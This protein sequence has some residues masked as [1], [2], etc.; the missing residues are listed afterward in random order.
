M[1]SSLR[2]SEQ[3]QRDWM[4][5]IGSTLE[6][7]C[8]MY[9]AVLFSISVLRDHYEL[10]FGSLNSN[11]SHLGLSIGIDYV[12]KVPMILIWYR[13]SVGC[14]VHTSS[15]DDARLDELSF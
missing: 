11:C 10:V 1:E 14:C 2:Y 7:T 3:E 15:P 6:F 13:L 8:Q 4:K 9:R 5:R 12:K